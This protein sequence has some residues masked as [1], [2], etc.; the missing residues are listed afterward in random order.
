MLC[1]VSLLAII[2]LQFYLNLGCILLVRRKRGDVDGLLE[3]V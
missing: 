1:Y 2:V 3:N